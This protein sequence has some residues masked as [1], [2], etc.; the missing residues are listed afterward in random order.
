VAL[1]LGE[2]LDG[3]ADKLKGI[4]RASDPAEADGLVSSPIMVRA[5]AMAGASLWPRALSNFSRS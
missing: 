3:L 4:P 2:R 1:K 5:G